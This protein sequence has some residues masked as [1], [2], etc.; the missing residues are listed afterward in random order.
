METRGKE[1]FDAA[2]CKTLCAKRGPLVHLNLTSL[3][4]PTANDVP[5]VVR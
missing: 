1:S 2:H 5:D 3:R 4:N